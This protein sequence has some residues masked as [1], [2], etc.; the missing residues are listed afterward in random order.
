L[1]QLE[2]T[3][4]QYVPPAMIINHAEQFSRTLPK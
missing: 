1:Y 2:T 4:K 3:V